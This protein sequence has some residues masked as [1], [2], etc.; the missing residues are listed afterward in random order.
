MEL[1]T[2]ERR[3]KSGT[4][5]GWGHSGGGDGEGISNAERDM[6]KGVEVDISPWGRR[7]TRRP[8]VQEDQPCSRTCSESREGV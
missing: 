5:L 3:H 1:V 6:S 8:C 4:S 2:K 7:A